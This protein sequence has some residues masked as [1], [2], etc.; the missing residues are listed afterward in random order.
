WFTP[1]VPMRTDAVSSVEMLT[2]ASEKSVILMS[3]VG[4]SLSAIDFGVA[5][6]MMGRRATVTLN[7]LDP[8]ASSL[9]MTDNATVY[10][11]IV[12]NFDVAVTVAPDAF[13]VDG[14]VVPFPKS[15]TACHGAS[16]PGS[17]KLPLTP[18]TSP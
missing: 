7:E 1:T 13:N 15:R 3:P 10:V 12:R 8:V 6:P 17:V 16:D 2:C 18:P 14:V 4:G 9:S 5:S 11:P